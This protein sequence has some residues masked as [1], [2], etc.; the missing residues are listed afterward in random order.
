MCDYKCMETHISIVGS[1]LHGY[2]LCISP[3]ATPE[4]V[5]GITSH[6]RDGKANSRTAD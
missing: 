6:T 4:K 3:S 2:F 5:T 1:N